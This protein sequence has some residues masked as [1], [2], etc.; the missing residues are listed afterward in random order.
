MIYKTR[1]KAL[2]SLGNASGLR[3]HREA[4]EDAS[5]AEIWLLDL[6]YDLEEFEKQ[7]KPLQPGEKYYMR[8]ER[9]KAIGK[10]I[11][12]WPVPDW[13]HV[14]EQIVGTKL[15]LKY[16]D[17]MIGAQNKPYFQRYMESPH[18]SRSRHFKFP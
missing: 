13:W 14:R 6:L 2:K 3:T 7:Q 17:I 10:R 12:L 9:Y 18:W 1:R 4:G 11:G 15:K 16:V 5:P 8:F